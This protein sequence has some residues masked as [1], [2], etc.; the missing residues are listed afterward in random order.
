MQQCLSFPR[1]AVESDAKRKARRSS[2]RS[3]SS[4]RL[5]SSSTTC[6]AARPS[7]S[8]SRNWTTYIIGA[9]YFG[10]SK[11]GG[12]ACSTRRST[13]RAGWCCTRAPRPVHTRRSRAH[14]DVM[15]ESR[16]GQ[17]HHDVQHAGR[18]HAADPGRHGHAVARRAR[19][20]RHRERLLRED[21]GPDRGERADRSTARRWTPSAWLE[22][23]YLD[24][25]PA[26][27]T[28]SRRSSPPTRSSAYREIFVR[29]G[30]K[31]ENV[32]KYIIGR[33]E[34]RGR[35]ST[36]TTGVPK[37]GWDFVLVDAE[38]PLDRADVRDRGSARTS[39]ASRP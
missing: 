21:R 15:G 9:D 34:V 13:A 39:S 10:E 18:A 20:T 3:A 27:W 31:A 8:T 29:T 33:G 28:S 17:D 30:S 19:C 5:T 32:D 23:V 6:R 16:H 25:R 12:C 38:R 11:K 14:R 22:N 35:A 7:S 37:D 1:E 26:R 4:T 24:P 36:P 2:R